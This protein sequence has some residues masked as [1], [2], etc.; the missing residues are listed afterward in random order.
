MKKMTKKILSLIIV[1]ALVLTMGIGAFAEE[2]AAPSLVKT[3]DIEEGVTVPNATF[4]FKLEELPALTGENDPVVSTGSSGFAASTTISAADAAAADGKS[5]PLSE[6]FTNA[7]FPHA[8]V[9]AYKLTEEA[10]TYTAADNETLTCNTKNA[11]YTVIVVVGNG[12]NGLVISKIQI[13]DKD[14]N[15][16][17]SA[18]FNNKYEK[19]NDDKA[20]TVSKTVA[21]AMG[22]KVSPFT[23]TLTI[24]KPADSAITT[25]PVGKKGTESVTLKW[26]A[27]T[28]QLKDGETLE[29][30][31]VPYGSTYQ[32]VEADTDSSIQNY[33]SYE[34]KVVVNGTEKPGKDTG[35]TRLSDTTANTVAFTNTLVEI[36]VTGVI[37]NTLPY[38]LIVAI[39]AAG[40]FYMQMKKRV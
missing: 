36:P 18:A 8:G 4:N 29:V 13:R 9:Y 12:A 16:T 24:T 25:V 26:G 6:L 1:S 7:T 27:N 33:A 23:F 11:E 21:G 17:G 20:L 28:I 30:K 34:T 15:K 38:V 35:S 14:G 5:I 37:I 22:D 10:A 2:E 40:F 19:T 32:V 39:A 31:G 3:L